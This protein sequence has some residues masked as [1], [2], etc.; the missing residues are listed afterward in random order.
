[1]QLLGTQVTASQAILEAAS[2]GDLIYYR[3]E[4]DL[5]SLLKVFLTRRN[6]LV[7]ECEEGKKGMQTLYYI[8]SDFIAG[9]GITDLSYKGMVSYLKALFSK[10]DNCWK[11]V[12]DSENDEM[13]E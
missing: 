12:E 4:D 6:G 8:W 10:K 9:C 5:E 1:M 3:P 7:T 11:V 13:S 2:K